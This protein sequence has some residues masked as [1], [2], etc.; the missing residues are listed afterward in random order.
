MSGKISI[1]IKIKGG[2]YADRTPDRIPVSQSY[3]SWL[4][5]DP[6]GGGGGASAAPEPAYIF[7]L[8]GGLVALLGGKKKLKNLRALF[9]VAK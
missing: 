4:A 7:T 3:S 9:G 8:L 1:G 6:V 5:G 2:I